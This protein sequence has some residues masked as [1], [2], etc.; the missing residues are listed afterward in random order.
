MM[1][2]RPA[3][4]IAY[5]PEARAFLH[6]G[7]IQRF[8]EAGMAPSVF[9]SQPSSEALRSLPSG[10]PRPF[11][12][13]A[14]RSILQR[15]RGLSRRKQGRGAAGWAERLAAELAGGTAGWRRALLEVGAD[16]LIC[17]SHNSAR[18][19][20]ALQTAANMGLPTVVLENSWKDVHRG[21]YAPAAPTA[22]GFTTQAAREAYVEANGPPALFEVCGSLHLSALARAGS[23]D[24]S[25]FCRRLGLDPARPIVCY[26]TARAG[27]IE[28][29]PGWVHR[30]WRRFQQTN[31]VCPQLL[32]RTN[33]MDESAAFAALGSC[34]DV[35]LLRPRWEWDPSSDWCCP[36]EQD[37]LL[38]ASAI[39]HSALN[40]SVASTV[41][42]EFAAY[43]RPVINP[44]FGAKARELC[45]SDF[46]REARRNGWAQPASTWA[47][48]EDLIFLHLAEPEKTVQ[49]APL[50]DATAK[51]LDLVARLGAWDERWTPATRLSTAHA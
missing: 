24:R 1:I 5:G 48:L 32:V 2:R 49:R 13:G 31:G 35:A 12:A 29:E 51:A 26:S 4:V 18:T 21:A 40:V 20:P 46:Y 11:P 37:A 36:L 42:L 33:P 38:W 23:M 16:A 44:V 45:D 9:A 19:L 6:S 10:T 25:D 17:A 8:V 15:L 22:M 14:E 28:A 7:L 47:E 30:L 27:V 41:A 50:F 43:G 34:A 39:T 3:L